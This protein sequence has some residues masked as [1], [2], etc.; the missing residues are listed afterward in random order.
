MRTAFL[1]CLLLAAV[2][3]AQNADREIE[4]AYELLM[5]KAAPPKGASEAARKAAGDEFRAALADFL[6]AY[7]PRA[8][9]LSTGRRPLA[10]AA[11]LAGKPAVAIPHLEHFVAKQTTHEDFEEAWMDLGAAYLD[12]GAAGKARELY[13]RFLSERP[14]SDLATAARFYLGVSLLD[15]G[16]TD[17][18]LAALELVAASGGDHPLV[19]DARFKLIRALAEA[20]RSGEAKTRLSALLKEAP[21]AAALLSL[22]EELDRLGSAPPELVGIR[23]WLG[24]GP[25]TLAA[26]KGGVVVLCFFAD[27]YE[28]SRA[29]LGAMEALAKSFAGRPVT[30]VALTTYYR[31]K[32]MTQ[33]EEDALLRRTAATNGWTTTIG[34]AADFSLLRAYGVRGVPHTVVVGQ[35]GLVVHQKSGAGRADARGS[36]A[37]EAAIRRALEPAESRPAK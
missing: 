33:D 20:G 1:W 19:A 17:D 16:R 35:D 31:R 21:D 25:V 9:E 22:K 23:T 6:A 7:E 32:S 18:G 11:L 27:L 37:L 30:F 36:A 34:V 29:E 28:A 13:E 14:Q 8:G 4:K 2:V 3:P 15:L 26:K 5:K 10:R 24:N 12:V